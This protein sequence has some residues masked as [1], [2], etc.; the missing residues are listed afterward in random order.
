MS[1]KATVIELSSL[2]GVLARTLIERIERGEATPS[3]MSVARQLLKDNGIEC[4]GQKN[5]DMQ[6]L[7]TA[8][9]LPFAAPDEVDDGADLVG[10]V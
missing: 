8:T 1:K 5:S 9:E 3:E 10:E 6:G 4:D 2:H 7:K